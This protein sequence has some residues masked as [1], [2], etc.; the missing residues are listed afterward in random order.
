MKDILKQLTDLGV[1]ELLV[2]NGLAT[3]VNPYQQHGQFDPDYSQFKDF[4]ANLP[5]LPTSGIPDGPVGIDE[6]EPVD[7]Y[8]NEYYSDNAEAWLWTDNI[9]LYKETHA[10]RTAIRKKQPEEVI[11]CTLCNECISP[12]EEIFYRG[13]CEDCFPDEDCNEQTPEQVEEKQQ[14]AFKPER[15]TT[16]EEM[17][18]HLGQIESKIETLEVE[19]RYLKNRIYWTVNPQGES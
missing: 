15:E 1:K 5:P 3:A 19:R 7:E 2:T 12:D 4:I 17:R 14:E 18:Y 8:Y 6:V 13:M 16:L 9:H 10:T 11:L